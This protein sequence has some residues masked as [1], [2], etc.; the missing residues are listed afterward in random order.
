MVKLGCVDIAVEVSQFFPFLVV[1]QKGNMSARLC[2]KHTSHLV[3]YPNHPPITCSEFNTDM[4][5]SH[6]G[7][8]NVEK[9]KPLNAPKML[10]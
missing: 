3:L 8:G 9:A 4:D 2:I 6:V 7:C 5:W 1:P 10:G